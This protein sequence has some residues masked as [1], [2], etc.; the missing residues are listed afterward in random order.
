MIK[1]LKQSRKVYEM[2]CDECGSLLQ[3]E[4]DDIQEGEYSMSYGDGRWEWIVCPVCK[5]KVEVGE[6]G[7]RHTDLITQ[8][9]IEA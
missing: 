1:V 5:N 6:D 2:K 9:F 4:E 3:F 7:S 8:K